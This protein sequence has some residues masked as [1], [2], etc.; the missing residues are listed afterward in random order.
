L[1]RSE[2]C[3]NDIEGRVLNTAVATGHGFVMQNVRRC[4]KMN[5]L[6]LVAPLLLAFSILAGT[7]ALRGPEYDEGYTVLV[8]NGTPR[9]HWPQV[10]FR[11]GEMRPYFGDA[12]TPLRIGSDLRRGDVHPPL[13]FWA[14]WAWRR[15]AGNG[16]VALRLLSVVFT[17]GSLL[18]VGVI[19][20]RIGVPRAPSIL[21]T[22]FCYGFAYTGQDARGFALAHLLTLA[23]VLMALAAA[24][25]CR[26]AFAAGAG[27]LL[28]L[29]TFANYLAVF[30]GCATLLWLL[31]H[32]LR[33]PALW[34]AAGV[35]F[36]AV[37][38]ADLWFFLAQRD[39]R[40]GQFPPFDLL[41]ATGRLGRYAA[42]NIFGGLPLYVSG[43]ARPALEVALGA[44]LAA[45]VALIAVRWRRIGSVHDRWLMAMNTV[46]PV[47][48]LLVLGAVF[49]NTPIELRY[50]SFADPYFAMLLAGALA[51]L[52]RPRALAAGAVVLAVQ[53]AALVGLAVAPQTMQPQARITRKAAALA[54]PDGLVLVPFGNDGV[55]AVGATLQSA[56][57]WLRLLVIRRGQPAGAIRAATAGAQRVVVAAIAVDP[58]SRA[59]IPEMRD[60]FAGSDCWRQAGGDEDAMAYDRDKSCSTTAAITPAAQ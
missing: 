31:L 54:G 16:L 49:N 30:G 40:V 22:L 18:L 56:P 4:L 41:Q 45:C 28:S 32:R 9:P 1:T 60:A 55:G 47:L 8:T 57:D 50:L 51:S 19:A 10:P 53:A 23:G 24:R 37:I 14:A 2:L 17:L 21:F 44:L 13:Y 42:G 7:A 52:T 15:I 34:L 20:E 46:A 3:W 48:G 39:S 59:T 29:G 58:A 38:P 33:R 6:P 26:L 12:G 11:A 27:V 5:T 36:L 35:G 25:T 43:T